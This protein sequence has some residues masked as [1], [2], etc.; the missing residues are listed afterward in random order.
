M[1]AFQA[2]HPSVRCELVARH[3]VGIEEFLRSEKTAVRYSWDRNGVLAKHLN[4]F[5][6][7]RLYL[8]D[9]EGRVAYV[10]PP[11]LPPEKAFSDVQRLLARRMRERSS[12][13]A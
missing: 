5:F 2:R 6:L 9:K 1:Q 13:P 4:A 10:E 11:G 8:L 7:P 3:R 12:S